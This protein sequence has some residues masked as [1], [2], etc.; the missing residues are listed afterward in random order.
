MQ[1]RHVVACGLFV[2]GGNPSVAGDPTEE[3]FDL[4][5]VLAEF[6]IEW[7]LDFAAFLCR[8]YCFCPNYTTKMSVER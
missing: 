4:V 7:S 1:R 3:A 8:D 2:A 5:A 6:S